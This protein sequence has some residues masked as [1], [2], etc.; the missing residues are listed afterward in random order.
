MAYEEAY[1]ASAYAK[2]EFCS[3]HLG[4]SQLFR[5]HLQHMD[6]RSVLRALLLSSPSQFFAADRLEEID[7]LFTIMSVVWNVKIILNAC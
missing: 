5:Q 6:H 4:F 3:V 1:L 2:I 7:D